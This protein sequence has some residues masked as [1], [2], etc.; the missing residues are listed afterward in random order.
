M[1]NFKIC[2]IYT[3]KSEADRETFICE[4]K[5][6]GIV[7]QIRNEDGCL[8]YEYYLS[9]D[10]AKRI[11]L[12]EEWRDRDCQR[13]HMTQPHMTLAMQIKNRYIESTEIKTV[14]IQ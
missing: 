2:V 5:N 4:L 8:K 13:I 10:D 9:L 6:S 14:S 7:E 3:A 12:F 1:E 11:V